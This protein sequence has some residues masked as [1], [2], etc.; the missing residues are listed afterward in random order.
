[1][2]ADASARML[3]THCSVQKI[4]LLS[5]AFCLIVSNAFLFPVPLAAL[6]VCR[7]RRLLVTLENVNTESMV[8]SSYILIVYIC[9]FNFFIFA[10]LLMYF[11]V[12]ISVVVYRNCQDRRRNAVVI[13]MKS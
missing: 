12:L 4:T 13:L 5:I 1:M 8:I 3:P 2:L 9:N 10:I 7:L 6:V 11:H